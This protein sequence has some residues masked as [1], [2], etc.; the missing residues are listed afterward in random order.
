MKCVTPSK[1]YKKDELFMTQ[2]SLLKAIFDARLFD[3]RRWRNIQLVSTTVQA[4][5]FDLGNL[6]SRL[7]VLL[8]KMI[9]YFDESF[10]TKFEKTYM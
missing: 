2:V 1:D 8:T 6:Q 4:F 7:T 5:Q 10:R 9:L 3:P